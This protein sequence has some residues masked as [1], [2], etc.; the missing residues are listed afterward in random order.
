MKVYKF[1]CKDCGSKRYE[2]LDDK[3]YRCMYCGCVEELIL[4]K[5]EQP[6][7]QE[8]KPEEKVFEPEININ[9]KEEPKEKAEKKPSAEKSKARERFETALFHFLMCFFLGAIGVHRFIEGKVLTGLLYLFTGGLFFIGYAVDS[10]VRLVKLV[11]A[12]IN[13]LKE[14]AA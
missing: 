13:L 8:P 11:S 6:K 7:Q 14:E 9:P 5:Q 1:Q 10:V 4:E 2:K 3:T 12:T